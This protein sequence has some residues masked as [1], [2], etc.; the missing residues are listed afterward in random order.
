MLKDLL[1][2]GWKKDELEGLDYVLFLKRKR[3]IL[4][5][6]LCLLSALAAF[7]QGIYDFSEG[8]P[9]VAAIDASF[10]LVLL[11]GHFLNLKN[12]YHT[13]TVLIFFLANLILFS[14]SAVVPKGVGIYFY[15]FPL[16]TFSFIS[17]DYQHRHFSFGFTILSLILS[18]VLIL[19]N[20][21]PFGNINLQPFDPTISF[22]LN[23]LF[24]IIM[25]SLGII[26]LIRL[27]FQWEQTLLRQQEETERLSAEVVKKNI[28]LEKTNQEL[29]Q[30]VYSTSHDLRA[31]LASILGLVNLANLED[32]SNPE[33]MANY[34]KMIK[35]R[36]NSLDDFIKDIIDYSR[37]SRVEV[38]KISTDVKKLI[39]DV[40]LNNRFHANAEKVEITST[41]HISSPLMLDQNRTF[42]V[43]NNLISN[44]IKY[45]DMEKDNPFIHIEAFFDDNYLKI[46]IKDNGIGI[47]QDSQDRIFEMFYRGT[48][49]ADGSGL[50]LYIAKEMVEKMSGTLKFESVVDKETIFT[51]SIPIS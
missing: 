14:F 12:Y 20:F 35:E 29:D 28:S 2:I 6:Q 50:G 1:F 15:F 48:E 44:A 17:Y 41:I 36:V 27:N 49:K 40:L 13:A 30:F 5:S 21:Q 51:V 24:S 46:I 19:T 39:E 26:F 32:Q 22:A 38:V 45:S 42:R 11:G 18:L 9:L 3:S 10:G 4:F 43:L 8:Y 33:I 37:N 47:K 34:L 16:I 23:M 31:P 25:L 7:V